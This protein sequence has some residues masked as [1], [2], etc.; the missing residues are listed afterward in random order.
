MKMF[1]NVGKGGRT[2][3]AAVAAAAAALKI[4]AEGD[5]GGMY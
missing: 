2:A 4:H 5:E 1:C 3:L